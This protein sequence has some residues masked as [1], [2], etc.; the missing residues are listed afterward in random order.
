MNKFMKNLNSRNDTVE[1]SMI[2]S[3]QQKNR[4]TS[5]EG[6]TFGLTSPQNASYFQNSQFTNAEEMR[7]KLLEMQALEE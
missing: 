2:K 1:K 4:E 5:F 7:Q 3:P 6:E